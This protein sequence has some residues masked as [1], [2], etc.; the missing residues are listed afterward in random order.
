MTAAADRIPLRIMVHEAW[1]EIELSF[2]ETTTVA[3]VKARALALTHVDR[4]PAIFEVKYRGALITDE[5][6]TLAQVGIGPNAPLIVLR[7]RRAP[8]R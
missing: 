8:V 2:P 6:Q 7:A 1:D 4:D 5:D 3:Q